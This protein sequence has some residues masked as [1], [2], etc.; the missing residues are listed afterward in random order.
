MTSFDR[1]AIFGFACA[2]IMFLSLIFFTEFTELSHQNT[3]QAVEKCKDGE[4]EKIDNTT[5]YCADGA[6]YSF[7]E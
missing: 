3:E 2:S 4:W 7:G 5:I 6:E 1:G